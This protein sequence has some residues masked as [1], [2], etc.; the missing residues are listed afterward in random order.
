M[1]TNNRG[2]CNQRI[3]TVF[4]TKADMDK[5]IANKKLRMD[6]ITAELKRIYDIG[7]RV[8]VLLD[9]DYVLRKLWKDYRLSQ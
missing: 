8:L 2:G 4:F 6:I 9:D 7:K 5:I 3:N 1:Q